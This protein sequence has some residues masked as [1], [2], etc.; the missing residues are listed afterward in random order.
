VAFGA[1]NLGLPKHLLATGMIPDN[2][3]MPKSKDTDMGMSAKVY[4]T[5]SGT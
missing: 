1:N 4:A 5:G 3:G 2:L